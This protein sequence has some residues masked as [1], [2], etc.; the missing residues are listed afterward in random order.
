MKHESPLDPLLKQISNCLPLS[1]AVKECLSEY[2]NIRYYPRHF[3]FQKPG[4][5]VSG[6]CMLLKGFAVA[7]DNEAGTGI[8][9]WFAS[10]GQLLTPAVK[11]GRDSNAHYNIT[12]LEDS[13]IAFITYEHLAKITEAFPAFANAI[14]EMQAKYNIN[15][16]FRENLLK[17]N[18]V[19][20]RLRFFQL[21]YPGL[22]NRIESS[23]IT[24]YLSISQ[25][26][27]QQLIK[28]FSQ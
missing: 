19:S 25:N 4:E 8:S 3:V 6:L 17:H 18:N 20:E 21:A 26:E 16:G 22:E 15:T 28:V 14:H 2:T 12:V 10:E 24:S 11:N 7:G 27:Y 13:F 1:A 23:R 5:L 9:Y